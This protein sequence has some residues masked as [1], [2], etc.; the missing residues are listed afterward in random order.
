MVL[1][2]FITTLSR[3]FSCTFGFPKAFVVFLWSYDGSVPLHS[4]LLSFLCWPLHISF[5]GQLTVGVLLGQGFFRFGC[6]NEALP[7]S[8]TDAQTLSVV[9]E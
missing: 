1:D 6:Q 2:V 5:V 9:K 4:L 3:H 7:L 8:R